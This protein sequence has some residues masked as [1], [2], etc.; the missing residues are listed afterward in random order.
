M[1]LA[2]TVVLIRAGGDEPLM[3]FQ[4][5]TIVVENPRG[6]VRQGVNRDTGKPWKT[7]MKYPYGEIKDSMGLDGDP[8]DV[9]V[10]PHAGAQFAYVIHQ[11]NPTTGEWDEDKCMLGFP[12]AMTAK[13]AY[14]I[15]YDEPKKFFGSLSAVPMDRFKEIV[16][17]KTVGKIAGSSGGWHGV[18]FD[19]TLATYTG[20]KGAT[21]TG[22]PIQPMVKRIKKWLANGEDVRIF[23]ARVNKGGPE[24]KKAI[25]DWCVKHI[26]QKLPVTNIKDNKM[27]DLWDD[28]AHRV[29]MNTGRVLASQRPLKVGDPVTVDGFQGRAVVREIL[30]GN[31]V[32]VRFW[33][34]LQV[35]RSTN[36]VHP[37][38]EN[39]VNK[40]WQGDNNQHNA[41]RGP[42]EVNGAGTSQGAVKGWDTRGRGKN[43]APDTKVNWKTKIPFDNH[44]IYELLPSIAVKDIHTYETGQDTKTM[45]GFI[46]SMKRGDPI[47]AIW[48]HKND[49]GTYRIA[50][51]HHRLRAI[52]QLGIENIPA[53][54]EY[55]GQAIL[56]RMKD[57]GMEAAKEWS[58]LREG[59]PV[60]R[61]GVSN[62]RIEQQGTQFCVKTDTKD[63]NWGCFPSR[64][65]AE[66]RM[67]GR[68][69][70][71]P[72]MEE[73]KGAGTPD[74]ARKGW[75]TRGRKPREAA[76]VDPRQS[77]LYGPEH[78]KE[79]TQWYAL[80]K[81]QV[82]SLQQAL[83]KAAATFGATTR[84]VDDNRLFHDHETVASRFYDASRKLLKSPE[85]QDHLDRA[86]NQ[87]EMARNNVGRN[88]K[89][90]L[91][92]L[93]SAYHY[94]RQ[95]AGVRPMADQGTPKGGKDP[96]QGELF[97]GG[98]GSGC[99]GENCGRPVTSSPRKE[100]STVGKGRDF[101][102]GGHRVAYSEEKYQQGYGYQTGGDKSGAK[103]KT[104]YLKFD[105]N[106]LR[107]LFPDKGAEILQHFQTVKGLSK[108][109]EAHVQTRLDDFKR[110]H[111]IEGAMPQSIGQKQSG[112]SYGF[113]R[114]TGYIPP[115]QLAGFP[116]IAKP[117]HAA[118]TAKAP[119]G[120]RRPTSPSLGRMKKAGPGMR[121][122]NVSIPK[123]VH[124]ESKGGGGTGGSGGAAGGH[125]SAG[126]GASPGGGTGGVGPGLGDMGIRT[127]KKDTGNYRSHFHDGTTQRAEPRVQKNATSAKYHKK[128]K[129]F[130]T[131]DL[132]DIRRRKRGLKAD[133]G[134]EPTAGAYSTSNIDPVVWFRPPSLTKRE[135]PE[136][137]RKNRIPSDDPREDNDRF[138]DVTK[139]NAKDTQ[140]ERMKLT[141]K[142]QIP[143]GMTQVPAHTTLIVP[144]TATYL[145]GSLDATSRIRR[146][147][148]R[149]SFTSFDRRGCI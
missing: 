118:P 27:I 86:S 126:T 109:N 68:P 95:A 41:T 140:K 149:G 98:P 130:V 6:S 24:V 14:E 100:T 54:R 69:G 32:R 77:S 131:K 34:T 123:H 25:E 16:Y 128:F 117:G 50:D 92:D 87:L 60:D 144:H 21:H 62:A 76:R 5:M 28:K 101:F 138:L 142:Q 65:Q 18:D 9:Y 23:T 42:G 121:V 38:D 10:G 115:R 85:A 89:I 12:D 96:R 15:H 72:D 134:G 110:R 43:F 49:D 74:G 67:A 8:V 139:R 102:V 91:G 19:G 143:G 56:N 122:P 124:L 71:G 147:R 64:E 90:A 84:G 93:G 73:T 53:I 7:E 44:A 81:G 58:E 17:R 26:G 107:Q 88:P 132:H 29:E 51:G 11:L 22:K 106:G 94:L 63:E 70:F 80:R 3:K 104:V 135:T 82:D 31:R 145:P 112:W 48:V 146:G 47:R 61:G 148:N 20:W 125:G 108:P 113:R 78:N 2:E 141:K 39:S 136:Q 99:H 57:M 133:G 116:T 36:Y 66:A 120:G 79:L 35:T 75:D 30:P 59:R 137:N 13:N 55:Q 105:N 127:P 119:S 46:E 83:E 45:K 33:N 111:N 37:L 52:R 4:G 1:N 129:E 114:P 97:A 103:E 40:M